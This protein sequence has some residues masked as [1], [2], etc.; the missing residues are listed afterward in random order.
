MFEVELKFPLP[1]V[2]PVAV[3]LAD[4]GAEPAEAIAQSD[5]YFNHPVRDFAQSDEAFRVRSIGAKNF[6]T[7]KGP[8]VDTQTKTRREIELPLGDGA[9]TARQFGEM[10]IAL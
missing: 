4:L 10:L 2:A 1:D 7:Y 5:V 3:K 6:V 9:E 8:V